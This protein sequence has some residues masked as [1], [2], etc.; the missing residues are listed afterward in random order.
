M[1]H[2]LVPPLLICVS[3]IGSP[4]MWAIASEQHSHY[5]LVG[6]KASFWFLVCFST[7]FRL[8]NV[9]WSIYKDLGWSLT[10]MRLQFN[11]IRV[12]RDFNRSRFNRGWELDGRGCCRNKLRRDTRA[13]CYLAPVQHTSRGMLHK[14]FHFWFDRNGSGIHWNWNWKQENNR[15]FNVHFRESKKSSVSLIHRG[16]EQP[17][18]KVSFENVQRFLKCRRK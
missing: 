16:M 13:Y 3:K 10:A 14:C 7:L 4:S 18:D 15:S 9:S 17:W 1:M 2:S 6:H 8:M 12:V 5:Y 11:M